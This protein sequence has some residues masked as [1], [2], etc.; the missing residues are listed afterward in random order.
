M[1][2]PNYRP[3]MTFAVD[4]ALKTNYLS[5]MPKLFFRQVEQLFLEDFGQKPSEMFVDFD[6]E[7]IA[8][9]SLAQVHRAK[10][11][12]GREVAVKVLTLFSHPY[13]KKIKPPTVLSQ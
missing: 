2:M 4:L 5:I 7:P 8:A 1:F 3:D 9:A 11:Q 10:T 12:D 6:P 13:L